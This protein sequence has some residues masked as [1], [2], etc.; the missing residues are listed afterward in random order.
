MKRISVCEHFGKIGRGDAQVGGLRQHIPDGAGVG[1]RFGRRVV[2]T[3]LMQRP[4]YKFVHS[5]SPAV[6]RQL[7]PNA[8]SGNLCATGGD[9]VGLG[10]RAKRPARFWFIRSV[11]AG[12]VAQRGQYPVHR[13]AA[14][15]ESDSNLVHC[16][17]PLARLKKRRLDRKQGSG[18]FMAPT[19]S[20]RNHR[21]QML[22]CLLVI[23]RD[24]L[25]KERTQPVCQWLGWCIR[26]VRPHPHDLL[27]H[28][29]AWE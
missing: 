29:P 6:K 9:L 15:S 2:F 25:E 8:T 1:P 13:T 20:S 7:P 19:G 23:I 26:I 27:L 24:G 11:G 18:E 22:D 4:G 21:L 17:G 5:L 28:C 16:A 14:A 10:I 12:S 3:S